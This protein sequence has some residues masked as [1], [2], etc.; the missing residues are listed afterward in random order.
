MDPMLQSRL[1]RAARRERVEALTAQLTVCWVAAALAGAAFILIRR[2]TGW[3][4]RLTLPILSSLAAGAASFIAVHWA[5]RKSDDRRI[6]EKIERRYPEL[7]GLLLTAVQQV[8][9]PGGAPSYLQH[10]VIEEAVVRSRQQDWRRIT[11]GWR[12]GA[13]QVVHW[14]GL[15]ALIAILA[16]VYDG[17][18]SGDSPW[19]APGGV[20]VTPGDTSLERGESL[21]VLARFGR[22]LPPGV[23]LVVRTSGEAP[24]QIALVKSLADPVFGTSI[25]EVE[26]SLTYRLQYGAQQTRDYQVTVFERPRLEQADAQLT[27][28]AYTKL[29]PRRIE[30]TRRVTAVEG[31]QLEL[32][33]RLNKPVVSATLVAHDQAKTTL[34]L[35]VTEGKAVAV[36]APVR[37]GASQTYDLRLVDREGRTN[38]LATPIVVEILPNRLPELHVSSPKGDQRPSPVEELTFAGNVLGEFGL[39]GY[40]LAYTLVGGQTTFV[41]L[42]QAVPPLEKR[43]FD[44]VLRLED[45]GVQPD[46]LLSWYI[47]ADD[48]GPDDQPRRTAGDL[49][50]AEIRRFDESFRESQAMESPDGAGDAGGGASQELAQLEKQILSATW[51]LQRSTTDDKYPADAKVVQAAQKDALG[52]ATKHQTEA[53]DPRA[54]ELWSAVTSQMNSAESHLQA[55]AQTPAALSAALSAEQAAYQSLLRLQPRNTSVSRSRGRGGQGGASQ[56]QLAQLDLTQEKNRYETEKQAAP[57]PN[58]GRTEQLQ[59]M[60]RLQELARRQQDVNDRLKEMQTALQ[61]AKTEAERQDLRK[62]L[63]R[64]QEEQQQLVADT[65]ELRQRMDQQQNQAEMSEQRKQLEKTRGDVQTAADAAAQGQISEALASGTRAQRQFQT[66]RDQLHQQNSNQFSDELKGMRAAAR[67]LAQK[68]EEIGQKLAAP[69]GGA[70]APKRLSDDAAGQGPPQ[71]LAEQKRRLTDLVNRAKQVSQ[72][73]ESSE[74]LLSEKLYDSVRKL[75]QEDSGTAKEFQQ[76]LL[77]SG[78]LT[79]GLNEQL[80]DEKATEGTKSLDLTSGLVQKGYLPQAGEAQQRTQEEL[81]HFKTGVEQA[82]ESVIGDDTA[83]LKLAQSEL[84]TVMRQLREE[85]Q[86]AGKPGSRSGAAG[87]TSPANQVALQPSPDGKDSQAGDGDEAPS[88]ANQSDSRTAGE[89]SQQGQARQLAGASGGDSAASTTG[90]QASQGGQAPQLAGT[91]PAQG[92]ASGGSDG[93]PGG[94]ANQAWD[95]GAGGRTARGPVGPI[96]GEGYGQW[97]DRLR[98]V[99]EIVDSPD[100]RN[101]VAAAREHARLLRQDFARSGKRPEW[102]ELDLRI[103]KP[104]LD[105]RNQI[106]DELARRG[107]QDSLVPIDRDPV[108]NRYTESVRKYYESLGKDQ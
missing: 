19:G 74:P 39:S 27:Y 88:P 7:K 91:R 31:T 21:V 81:N 24:R 22:T 77:A 52:Q 53:E 20:V 68:E 108:P 48:T 82:A 37:F 28:P 33:L 32:D 64:L 2:E 73:A 13:F 34:P 9:A 96:T 35:R 56:R 36:L 100:L 51:K 86:S 12:V 65:D 93:Q 66:M 18:R 26:Q 58:A 104:L 78:L 42:G 94:A 14:A 25:P 107:S 87:G 106:A 105:V 1:R 47:W 67:E 57:G 40:G 4:S 6:A 92:A 102:A 79:R 15:A 49:F 60:N 99:E 80:T 45:L 70:A 69:A 30:N 89:A 16:D 75:A 17:G 44:Y 71:D 29:P 63:K 85:A 43:P 72:E 50:F 62:Q 41:P 38:S 101:A 61:E 8:P 10:R 83:A 90:D 95:G 97:S 5:Y 3:A 76:S 11:P 54:Q 59:V 103:V 55:A 98:T 23:N 46:Q 84:D